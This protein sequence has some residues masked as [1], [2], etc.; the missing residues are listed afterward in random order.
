[1][2]MQKR[3]RVGFGDVFPN[4]A[5]LKGGVEPVVD[6]NQ[7]KRSDGSRPQQVD[8]ESGLLVWQVIVLD[9]DEQA[10][11]R[12]GDPERRQIVDLGAE[13]LEDP[14]HVRILQREADLDA[15][16]AERDVPQPRP[17]LPRLLRCRLLVHASLSPRPVLARL[18]NSHNSRIRM[19]G[20]R[21][22]RRFL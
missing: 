21:Q 5:F 13:G 19:R 11:K 2:A 22:A 10:G 3:F 15:E 1:M 6:F 16:E 8:Q 18:H 17:A 20:R 9:A 14:A 12:R 4:G 7:E